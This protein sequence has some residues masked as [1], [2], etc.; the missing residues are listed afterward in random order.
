MLDLHCHVVR[1]ELGLA[2]RRAVTRLQRTSSHY[3]SQV[4]H[5]PR[6]PHNLPSP[7]IDTPLLTTQQQLTKSI[8]KDLYLYTQCI[9]PNPI[10]IY[11]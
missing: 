7:H 1:C 6:L 3:P 11:P 2:G 9:S 8:Q 4:A 5:C 10:I